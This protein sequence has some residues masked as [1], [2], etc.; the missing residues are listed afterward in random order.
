VSHR[1]FSLVI[2]FILRHEDALAKSLGFDYQLLWNKEGRRLKD[3]TYHMQSCGCELYLGWDLI[4]E[5]RYCG[6]AM[7]GQCGDSD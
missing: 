2:D 1:Q 6:D 3:A 4:L 5:Q 7:H